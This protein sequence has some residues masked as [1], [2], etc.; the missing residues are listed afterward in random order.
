MRAI[1]KSLSAVVLM[2][3]ANPLTLA[4]QA[5]SFGGGSRAHLFV[6][7]AYAA[8]WLVIGAWVVRL[9]RMVRQLAATEAVEPST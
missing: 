3:A 7:L 4:A 8:A 1:M 9:G 5:S 6:Y 2:M